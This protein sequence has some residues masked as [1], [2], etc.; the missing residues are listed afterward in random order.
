MD[1][2][3]LN[4]EILPPDAQAMAAARRR[5]DDIAKPV[6]SL[7]ALEDAIVR[8]AGIQRSE[9]VEIGKR[10][11]IVMCADNGVLAQGVAQTPGRITAVMTQM[12]AARRS[13]VC[14]MAACAHADVLPVEIGVSQH[15]HID[16]L[17]DR[18]IADG[19]A[20]MTQGPAMTR[21]QAERAVQIGMDVV[22][23]CRSQGYALLATGEMGIGNTTTS[24][25]MASVL[26]GRDAEA[27]TGRGAGLS[28][29]GL[30]R[31]LDAIR[32]AVAINTP[33]PADAFDVLQKLGGFDIAGL[34]GVFLGGAKYGVPVLVDG[35]ISA[36]AALTAVR[37]CPAASAYMLASHV[38]AEPAGKAVLDALSLTPILY[39]GMRLGEGTGAAALLPVLDMAVRVYHELPTY[40]DI[41]M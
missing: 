8:I 29:E 16:G 6:G 38:S 28:D 35:F 10:A 7:G 26:L 13:S 4:R 12:I 34:A 37:L 33:D 39:A 3:Q 25:A 2:T 24:S 18:H 32:R 11:V 30:C 20:D 17:L 27:M 15:M 22:R 1:F 36:V 5:W 31:K 21:A 14:L 19:T 40:A 9:H 41:G 23:D